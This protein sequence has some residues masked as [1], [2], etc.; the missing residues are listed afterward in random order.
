MC[1]CAVT[2]SFTLL[3]TKH[4]IALKYQD[5]KSF[6]IRS[7]LSLEYP[8]AADLVTKAFTFHTRTL[9]PVALSLP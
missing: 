5:L 3:A 8:P 1:G 2:N 7:T 9:I 4:D 6:A